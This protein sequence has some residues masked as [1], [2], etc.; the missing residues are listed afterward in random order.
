MPSCW[1]FESLAQSCRCAQKHRRQYALLQRCVPAPSTCSSPTCKAQ[2]QGVQQLPLQCIR[3]LTSCMPAAA[4]QAG[5]QPPR[6]SHA[7]CPQ[8]L[9]HEASALLRGV[10]LTGDQAQLQRLLKL[11]SGGGSTGGGHGG[12]GCR[13][14]TPPTPPLALQVEAPANQ[15][16]GPPCLQAVAAADSKAHAHEQHFSTR[17]AGIAARQVAGCGRVMMGP[18]LSETT[19][20]A[21]ASP[22]PHTRRSLL[23]PFGGG[24]R[25]SL[26]SSTPEQSPASSCGARAAGG[27]PADAAAGWRPLQDGAARQHCHRQVCAA[28][29]AASWPAG[30]MRVSI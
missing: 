1:A 11:V 22:L 18:A 24:G 7:D 9:L 27:G 26:C 2:P 13:R 10:G 30:S 16:L 15:L 12:G 4:M 19:T 8:L 5:T 28:A 29:A 23:Q 21:A 17:C 3:A 20:G 25:C 14:A 6:Q